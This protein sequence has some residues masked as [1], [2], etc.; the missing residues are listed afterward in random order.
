[1]TLNEQINNDLKNSMKT[2]DSFTLGVIRM[3]K[4]A[5]QL[6]KRN[7]HDEVTDEEIIDVVTKQIK[8]RKDS[9]EEFKKANREDLINQN[10][11]EIKVLEKY[12]PEQLSKEEILNIIDE[13]FNKINPTS[14]REMGL[15]MKEI[16]PKVKGKADMGEISRVIKERM[17]NL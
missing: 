9:I 7:V 1:M 6:S 5:I 3:L 2:K 8:L 14:Q 11:E 17:N 15:I 10:K 12:L 4:G 13:A 16:T